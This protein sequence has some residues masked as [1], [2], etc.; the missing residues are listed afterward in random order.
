[1]ARQETETLDN[2]LRARM[3]Q[4]TRAERQLAVAMLQDYPAT[5]L[6][7]ITALAQRADVSAPT[8]TRM[9][10]KIGLDG[11]QAFQEALRAELSA[12]AAG[13]IVKRDSG[14][15]G[16][17]DSH[18]LNRFSETV[19]AN[20]QS[21]LANLNP[22]TFDASVELLADPERRIYVTG[23]RITRSLADYL[24]THLQVIR[25]D[26]SKLGDAPGVWPHYV[27]EMKR[28]DVL[29][30]FDIRRYE[31][32][33][34]RLAELAHGRG[35][36]I[37]LFTDQWGS[38]ISKFANRRFSCNVE[39]P[40][41]WDSSAAIL[42]IVEALIASVQESSWSATKERMEQLEDIFDSTRLFRKFV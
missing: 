7:S 29:V 2:R 1:M 21:T 13:P 33:L 26:V 39:A 36:D 15:A 30:L 37:I 18:L 24:F 38:P 4:F 17:P 23:G 14:A 22:T 8:V 9:L 11:F 41:A 31:N 28:G 19:I 25:S 3:E 42:L 6:G 27:L 40:S 20:L 16:A 32:T 5:A 35:V 34:L 10:R 12:M